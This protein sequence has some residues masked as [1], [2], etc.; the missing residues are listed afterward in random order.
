MMKLATDAATSSTNKSDEL[1]DTTSAS[2]KV[3]GQGSHFHS[4]KEPSG[5]G[6]TTTGTE[7]EITGTPSTTAAAPDPSS[8]QLASGPEAAGADERTA[9]IGHTSTYSSTPLA[10]GDPTSSMVDTESSDPTSYQK[11]EATYGGATGVPTG[12]ANAAASTAFGNTQKQ[13]GELC[14]SHSYL[15][16]S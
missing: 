9:A 4:A 11:P 1:E 13:T 8:A 3:T 14:P 12:A 6:S 2:G 5:L 16:P 7:P 10:K 15:A